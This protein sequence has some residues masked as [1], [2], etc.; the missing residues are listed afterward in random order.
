[1]NEQ[2]ERALDRA[3]ASGDAAASVGRR[4]RRRLDEAPG[5]AAAL[6][7][8]A[9][10]MVTLE[11]GDSAVAAWMAVVEADPEHAEAWSGLGDLF[12]QVGMSDNAKAC[13]DEAIRAAPTAERHFRQGRLLQGV[14]AIP[15][16]AQ[17]YQ[18]ALALDRDLVPAWFNL[19]NLLVGTGQ[20][21][22]AARCYAEVAQR[23][24]RHA[25]ALGNRGVVLR[26]LGRLEEAEESLAAAVRLQPDYGLALANLASV[27]ETLNKT[28]EAVRTADRALRSEGS[29]ALA[30]LV[31]ARLHRRAGELEPARLRIEEAIAAAATDP[32]LHGRALVEAG[33]VRDRL[34]DSDGAFAAWSRGQELLGSLPAA[35][36]IDRAA[37]PKQVEAVRAATER[38]LALPAAPVG[39]GPPPIFMVG[40]PRSGTTLTEQIL[41]AHP[42]LTTAEE[43][44]FLDRALAGAD[45]PAEVDPGEV[46]RR[47]REQT[48]DEGEA[49]LPL[50]DKL[51]LNLVHVAL[52][53][54]AFPDAR[55]VVNLRDPRD[56][57]LSCFAQDF[58]PNEAMVQFDRLESTAALQVSLMGL[59]LA[60]RDRIELPWLELRYEDLVDDLPTAARGLLAFLGL[61]WHDGVLAYHEAAARRTILTPSHQDVCQP[62]FRRARGRWRRYGAHLAPVLP[63]L[64]PLAE[65]L[66]YGAQEAR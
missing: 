62:I 1:M 56:V 13:F 52:L 3:A 37:W 23:D 59:W 65:A 30:N 40:F 43:R 50:V 31:R 27:Q 16:A 8:L 10:L 44:P 12:E 33:M 42:G 14:G 49:G 53:S 20:L 54:R 6:C 15:P 4:L 22:D 7:E 51:P 39:D 35:R 2:L 47:W 32:E 24:R 58:V 61:P 9:G 19:G 36:A 17:H 29:S 64:E 57:C 26:R 48:R 41:A 46:R 18:A 25:R 34:K 11:D 63:A 55:L 45:Y 66:G 38:L 60:L 21:P 5:D 28:G